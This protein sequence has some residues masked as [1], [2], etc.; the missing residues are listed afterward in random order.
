MRASRSG[1]DL[2][3]MDVLNL[4]EDRE[5]NTAEGEDKEVKEPA[6]D[7]VPCFQF[8]HTRYFKMF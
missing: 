3:T 7:T 2:Q 1:E 6:S 4:A 8:Q 5:G